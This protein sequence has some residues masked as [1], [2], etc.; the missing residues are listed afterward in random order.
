MALELDED[1]Y[2]WLTRKLMDIADECCAGRIISVLEGGYNLKALSASVASHVACLL[3]LT[4]TPA[5]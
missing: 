3:G 1:D 4:E 5:K 2:Q